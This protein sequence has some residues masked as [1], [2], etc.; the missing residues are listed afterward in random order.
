MY[1]SDIVL[2]ACN[3]MF[4][5]HKEDK[6]KGGYPYVFH[7][8][9]LASQMDDEDSVCV[10][11]LHDLIEDHGDKYNFE[12]LKNEGFSDAVIDALKLMTHPD[13]MPYMDYVKSISEN[14]IARKVKAADLKHN[15]DTRRVNGKRP[16]KYDLYIKALNFLEKN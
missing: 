16:P 11:L 12:M 3:I 2:K 8:F 13:G 15:L 1:Y 7:P 4:C 14:P 10:A 9:Y 6:D 5:A